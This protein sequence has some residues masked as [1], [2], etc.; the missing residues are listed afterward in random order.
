[1]TPC[2][3]KHAL[4]TGASTGIGRAT[5]L[6]LAR[7][8]WHVFATVRRTAD[9]DALQHAASGQLTPLVMDVT[10]AAQ[11]AATAESIQAHV[12]R[13]GLDALVN[14]AGVGVAWP[15]ELV[16][17]ELFKMQFAI[18]VEGQIAVTQAMLPLLRLATGRL[19]MIGSIG[20]RISMP[21]AG[22][23]TC[24]KHAVLALAETF[25]R[26]LAPWNIR[27]VLI[28]P[29][30][31]RT[32]AV[33]KLKA[34]AQ[35][36]LEQFGSSGEMLYGQAFRSMTARAIAHENQGSPPEVVAQTILRA[37]KSPK[38]KARYLVGKSANVLATL[39][40]LP[41]F[42]LDA[43]LRRILG[44]PRQGSLQV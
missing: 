22:P 21:F 14:N 28:E 37:L 36:A 17:L 32:D 3:S 13:R 16:P 1:M 8:G 34:D 41:P 33:D 29:A 19:I 11:I 10:Q 26:E 24:S 25:R 31:I 20:D 42:L 18:N 44:L 39:A 30:A 4:V 15:L 5:A 2:T 6:E 35:H 43:L 12:E 7:H 27:V 23:L 40:K 9:G 38:P